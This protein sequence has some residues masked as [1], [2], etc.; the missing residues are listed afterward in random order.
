MKNSTK[1]SWLLLLF[2]VT[3]VNISAQTTSEFFASGAGNFGINLPSKFSSV[4]PLPF[5]DALLSGMGE[6]FMWDS[7]SDNLYQV[8]YVTIFSD[9]KTLTLKE[10]MHLVDSLSDGLKKYS[11]ENNYLF[12]EKP[13]FFQ[14]NAGKEIEMRRATAVIITRVFVVN[15]KSYVVS[16]VINNLD[17]RT[18]ALQ[19]LDSFKIL[20]AKTRQAKRLEEGE[21]AALPQ[22]PVAA[23]QKSDAEDRNLKGKVKSVVEDNQPVNDKRRRYSEDHYND[24]GNLVR[25]ISY[26]M[27][28]PDTII[29]WGYI[30]GNR[31]NNSGYIEY[32]DDERPEMK[33]KIMTINESVLDLNQNARDERYDTKFTYKYND[34]GR[35][36]E[37]SRFENNGKLFRR[38][39]N[40]YKGNQRDDIFYGAD[41]SQWSKKTETLDKNGNVIEEISYDDAGKIDSKYIFKYEF[42]AQG[43]WIIQRAFEAKKVKGKIVSQPMWVSHRTITY[44]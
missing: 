3:F 32:D 33:D 8:Q 13:F 16:V 6:H 34:D 15:K 25:E 14:G 43:N 17:E 12:K 19:I 26:T 40:N 27:G 28:Y 31:V 1:T 41:G 11:G 42:D 36:I 29:V 30:D 35:L 9:R 7:Y 10:K 22:T 18:E 21:P 4:K 24:K 39:V 37:E 20:D 44:Y 2:S 38:R 23:K 5:E